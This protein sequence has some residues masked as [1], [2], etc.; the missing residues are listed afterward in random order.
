[1]QKSVSE[2]D[3][4]IVNPGREI[5]EMPRL[6]A[7]SCNDP[8]LDPEYPYPPARAIQMILFLFPLPL[9]PA[10]DE[11]PQTLLVRLSLMAVLPRDE[12]GL[13]MKLLVLHR[14]DIDSYSHT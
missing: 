5:S 6:S 14:L 9:A 1:M 11:A 4:E 7:S 3:F 2:V 8:S 12:V 10:F 13:Q